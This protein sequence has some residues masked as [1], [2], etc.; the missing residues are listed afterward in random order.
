MLFSFKGLQ[1]EDVKSLLASGATDEQVAA[2]LDRNGIP[3]TADEIK[4]WSD[5]VEAIHPYQ[6]PEQRDWFASECA[7]LGNDPVKSSTAGSEDQ[8]SGSRTREGYW[9]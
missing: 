2:W 5:S 7:R 6:D 8:R 9:F 4:A 3:K 1:A